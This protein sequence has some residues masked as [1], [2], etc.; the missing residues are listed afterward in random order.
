MNA[1][2][3]FINSEHLM[4]NI[5]AIVGFK[6][7]GK[8]TAADALLPFNY[9]SFSFADAIKDCLAAIF[10]WDRSMIEGITPESRRWRE[11]VDLWWAARLQMPHFTPRWAMQNFGTELMRDQFHSEIWVAAIERRL[12]LLDDQTSAILTDARFPNEIRLARD[13][14]GTVV[15]IQRGPDPNWMLTAERANCGSTS[16]QV[17]MATLGIHPSECAWIG[18]PTDAVID[19]DGSVEQLHAKV[20][21]QMHVG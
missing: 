16:D 10:C 7:S 11:Q 21:H 1:I 4:K 14:G 20:R 13:H 12:E 15:R 19:N 6:A 3:R 5:V 17:M 9:V 2:V 18:I 8:N